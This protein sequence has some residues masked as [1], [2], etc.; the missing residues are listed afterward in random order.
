[1]S[2]DALGR[3]GA[4][5]SSR[6]SA[7]GMCDEAQLHC[8]QA[9]RADSHH[10][11]RCTSTTARPQISFLE[12]IHPVDPWI[13]SE[14]SALLLI[15]GN[16]NDISGKPMLA[17]SFMYL[18]VLFSSSVSNAEDFISLTSRGIHPMSSIHIFF[19]ELD[20]R[21]L[22]TNHFLGDRCGYIFCFPSF[23]HF[24]SSASTS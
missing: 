14:Y 20:F 22:K 3:R 18:L 12:D 19:F 23:R 9:A 11:L 17:F 7:L 16:P 4:N 24:Q 13:C 10:V 15:K 2:S 1:M 8:T 6:C 21:D 5:I